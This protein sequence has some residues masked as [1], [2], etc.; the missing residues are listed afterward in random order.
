MYEWG[1]CVKLKQKGVLDR[2]HSL[3]N[4]AAS[5]RHGSLNKT[6]CARYS[7]PPYEVLVRELPTAPKATQAISI[8]LSC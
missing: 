4:S 8:A 6:L 7:L 3:V 2:C 5:R 1:V